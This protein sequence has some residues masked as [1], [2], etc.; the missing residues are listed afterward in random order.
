M[1]RRQLGLIGLIALTWLLG[2]MAP[3]SSQPAPVVRVVGMEMLSVA[4]GASQDTE[5]RIAVAEGFHVQANPAADEFLIPLTLEF[6]SG[7]GFEVTDIRYPPGESYRLQGADEDLLVCGGTFAVPVTVRA[8]ADAREEAVAARGRLR[9]Q[10]CDDRICL[11]A[12]T[13]LFDLSVRV[14]STPEP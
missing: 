7:D 2:A 13:L 1:T 4:P 6:V 12:A 9:Y 3:A 8:S 10:A 14:E 11:A 5:I